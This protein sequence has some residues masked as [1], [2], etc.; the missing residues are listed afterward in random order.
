MREIRA[1][2]ILR[3]EWKA[4]RNYLKEKTTRTAG[5]VILLSLW[6]LY[7]FGLIVSY[8]FLLRLP[9]S[10]LT[11]IAES[12]GMV[13]P[14]VFIFSFLV[15]TSLVSSVRR[16]MNN[17]LKLLFQAPINPKLAL[18]L[19]LGINSLGLSTIFI[20]VL[21]PLTVWIMLLIN[22][23]MLLILLQVAFLLLGLVVFSFL[24]EYFGLFLL[25]FGQ[26]GKIISGLG[27]LI[28]GVAVYYLYFSVLGGTFE[29]IQR[30]SLLTHPY[31][32]FRWFVNPLFFSIEYQ[33]L[34]QFFI[35]S[36]G[37][38]ASSIGIIYLVTSLT[39]S[40]FRSGSFQPIQ[41]KRKRKTIRWKQRRM[42]HLLDVQTSTLFRKDLTL[43]RREP[44]LLISAL[45]LV[46]IG[47]LYYFFMSAPLPPLSILFLS[48]FFVGLVPMALIS[49]IFAVEGR[50]LSH[51]VS[52]PVLLRK[53]VEGKALA[54][55][56]IQMIFSTLLILISYFFYDFRVWEICWIALTLFSLSMGTTSVASPVTVKFVDFMAENP[57]KALNTV[58][59]LVIMMCV[60]LVQGPY[61]LLTYFVFKGSLLA[62]IV[63][64]VFTLLVPPLIWT[65]GMNLAGKIL[66]N[67]RVPT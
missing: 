26:K 34:L 24:G 23:S 2:T 65:Y 10:L 36:I 15:G 57:R 48:F 43:I 22:S 59:G 58:G 37:V 12:L 35:A 5:L 56:L 21:I 8:P 13:L 67:R 45:A 46:F 66:S 44:D 64:L 61:I 47:V 60:G 39:I 32:P 25:R 27:G 18:F 6:A 29:V 51:L 30:M 55:L 54:A 53:I 9:V 63:G 16:G 17:Q 41:E 20:L 4:F 50:A 40:S 7:V 62:T 11:V 49:T 33:P 1:L 38:L 52:S 28:L 42:P 14:I 3:F 19:K 31:S